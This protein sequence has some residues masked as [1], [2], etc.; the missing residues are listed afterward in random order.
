MDGQGAMAA[1]AARAAV[2]PV[3]TIEKIDTAVPLAR[4]LAKGG[5]PVIEITLRTEVALEAIRAVAAEVPEAVVGAGTVLDPAQLDQVQ[6]A[7]CHF[8]VGP[9]CTE[10]LARR[11]RSSGVP[12]LPGVQ[13][14]SEAMALRE[15]GFRVLKFFPANAAGGLTWLA[16]VGAPL[17]GLRFCPTGGITAETAPAY[18]ALANVACVGG[19]WVAPRV[20]VAT[21]DWQSVERLASAASALKRR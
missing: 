5:L 17:S 20:A 15:L 1:I 9:G 4:A 6:R 12:F 8:A 10:A 16:A 3:L 14:V 7:G 19:S 11:A 2:I 13:T 21:G 18:L